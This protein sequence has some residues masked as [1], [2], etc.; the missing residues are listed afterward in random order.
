MGAHAHK[1]RQDGGMPLQKR[2]NNEPNMV[3]KRQK[4]STWMTLM[5]GK[6]RRLVLENKKVGGVV[7]RNGYCTGNAI[8]R[9]TD[10][11]CLFFF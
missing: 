3:L 6:R 8:M 4:N 11:L 7:E 9:S 5:R 2:I 10:L 1:R